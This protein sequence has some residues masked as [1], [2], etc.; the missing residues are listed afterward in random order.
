MNEKIRVM[1]IDDSA[2]MRN[3][4]ATTLSN[5]D[6]INVVGSAING[7]FGLKKMN[8]LK[9]DLIILDLEM[10]E[11]NGIEFLKERQKLDLKIPVIILSAH[12][13]KGAQITLEALS[14][15]ASDFILKPA[16]STDE[17]NKTK[18][19]LIELIIAL[20][21]PSSYKHNDVLIN[22]PTVIK[23]EIPKFEIP[24]IKPKDYLQK[25]KS[26][27]EINII[28]IGIS[29]GGPNALRNIL[30]FFP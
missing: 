19:R 13:Q 28:A 2:L 4:I 12:A 5:N 20:G 9:P 14:L 3:L 15:G 10:P 21:K 6:S 11:M 18:E 1:I 17:I 16:G 27:P 22:I 25:I 7:K 8:I 23:N 30:P 26:I 24:E 29:T